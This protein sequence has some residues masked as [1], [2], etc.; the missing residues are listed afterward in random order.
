[1]LWKGDQSPRVKKERMHALRGKWE[2]VFSGRHMVNF[3]TETHVVSVMT[4][5]TLETEDKVRDE[6][7]DRPLLHPKRRQNRLT[8]MDKNPHTDQATNRKTR[9][10][11]V[12]F[13]ADSNSVNIRHVDSGI[14][15]CV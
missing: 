3:P 9:W 1:M 14:L 4:S 13:H 12:K 11:R 2:S 7:G 8:A 10:I 6:K 15:P 5:K